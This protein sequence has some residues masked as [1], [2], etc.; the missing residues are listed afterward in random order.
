MPTLRTNQQNID[1]ERFWD[2]WNIIAFLM[3]ILGPTLAA[4]TFPRSRHI[5]YAELLAILA[6]IGAVIGFLG[7][8]GCIT[9]HFVGASRRLY[10]P[11]R[12]IGLLG[13]LAILGLIRRIAG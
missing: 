6:L 12:I 8:I 7:V 13:I 4:L 11:T 3:A 2:R 9:T 10:W 5:P 1:R